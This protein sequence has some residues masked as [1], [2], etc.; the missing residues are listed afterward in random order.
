MTVEVWVK[1]PRFGGLLEVSSLGRVRTV[2]REMTTWRGGKVK[3]PGRMVTL[4]RHPWGYFWCEFMLRRQK[5]CEFVHRLVAE[6]FHG[7]APEG[8]PYACHGDNNPQNNVP[9]NLRWGSPSDN[10]QDKWRHGT[11]PHGDQ[12]W[13]RK[14]DSAEV[15]AMRDMRSAGMKLKDISTF[16]GISQAQVCRIC[17]GTRWTA[18]DGPVA[19]RNKPTR[20][21]SD[22]EKLLVIADRASGMSISMLAERYSVSRSQIHN[23]VR[24]K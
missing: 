15:I 1:P 5:H 6:A 3:I 2:T 20:C 13:W 18:T 21:L 4:R 9:D 7:P 19:R 17:T 23:L 11:Q 8:M 22:D 12:I 16:Y 24:K 10:S 14:V